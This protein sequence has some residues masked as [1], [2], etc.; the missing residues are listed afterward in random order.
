MRT[1]LNLLLTFFFILTL[2]ALPYGLYYW[3]AAN[4]DMPEDTALV[5]G[6]SVFGLYALVMVGIILRAILRR[7]VSLAW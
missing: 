6:V 3:L 4:V 2:T 7:G 5:I 1:I